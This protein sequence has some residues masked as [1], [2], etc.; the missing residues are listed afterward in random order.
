[1]VNSLPAVVIDNGTSSTRAGFASEDLP[2]LVFNSG[3]SVDKNNKVLVGDNINSRPDLEVMTLVDN[4]IV[5]NYDHIVSNWEYAYENLDSGNGVDAKDHPL[6]MTEQTWNTPKNK[7]AAAQIAFESLQVPLFSL[8]KNPLAQLYHTGRSSGLVIDVGAGV[9]SV[10][11]ILDGVIQQKSCFHSKYA[12]DFASLH[13]LRSIEAKLGYQPNQLDYTRLLP[14]KYRSENVSQSFRSYHATHN[15]LQNFKETMLSVSEPPPGVTPPNAYYAQ[16]HQSPS[17]FQLPDRTQINYSDRETSTLL[18]ALFV[19]HVY[20]LP[21]VPIPDPAFDKANTH[22]IS[23]LVLFALKNLESTMVPSGGDP[24]SSNSN[25]RFNEVLRQL[26]TNTLITGGCAL[27]PGFSDRICGDI[28]RTAPSVMPN[29]MI[30]SSYKIYI[31]P[32]RNH[33][34]GDIH[35]LYDKKFGSWL[36]AANL[37]NM[38]NDAVEDE[39]GSANIALDNWFI[40]KADYEELGEDLIVEKFK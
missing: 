13:A 6:M 38:L 35:D 37:A 24:Q 21:D 20:K 2:S 36:G 7:A 33:P 8:L 14:A 22:G 5:Y 12:G 31:S 28:S 40:S 10:T 15:L 29:Y 3:Y 25:A 30:T 18:E 4:G 1:M 26:F 17:F 34:S 11:P 32:L 39:N 23:N 27:L 19:P 9:A 16:Q